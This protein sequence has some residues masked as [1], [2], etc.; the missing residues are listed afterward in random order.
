MLSCQKHIIRCRCILPQFKKHS[1]PPVHEFIVFSEI[2]DDIVQ[3]S[4][5]QCN[6][7]GIVHRIIDFC[8]SEILK[9]KE[10]IGAI[11]TI[12]DIC[13]SLP[14]DLEDLLKGCNSDLATFQYVDF[15]FRNSLW[16]TTILLTKE[17]TEGYVVGKSLTV[18]S[19][20]RFRIVPFTHSVE[21]KK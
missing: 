17:E 4:I 8:K 20:N 9:S 14:D 18:V 2:I 10:N 7:C 15:V 21:I 12:D 16:G 13:F 3:E 6:N 19:E 5:T 1:N 11:Q